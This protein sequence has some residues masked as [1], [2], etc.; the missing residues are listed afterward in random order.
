[1]GESKEIEITIPADGKAATIDLKGFH[2]SECSSVSKVLARISGGK[3]LQNKKKAEYF[4]KQVD[5]NQKQKIN[6]F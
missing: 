1:M 6:G 4:D 2:G 3:V 5:N